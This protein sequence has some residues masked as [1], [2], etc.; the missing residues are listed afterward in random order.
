[1]WREWLKSEGV[2]WPAEP[3]GHDA[4][5]WGVPLDARHMQTAWCADRAIQFFKL[6]RDFTP[7][8][9]SVNIFQPHHPFWPAREYFDRY[10]PGDVAPPS[11]REG[12]LNNKPIYQRVDHAGA[13]GG[14]D[15]S[16]RDTSELDHRRIKAAY[17][18]M[19]EQCDAE[20]GRMLEALEESGQADNTIVIFMSDHGEMLGD[21]GIFLKGPYFYE[22]A[23]R[24]PM[25]IRW[26]HRYKA[27]LRSDALVE[28]VDLAPTLLEAAGLPPTVAMQGRSL[29]PLLTG[30]T[31]RHRDSVYCEFYDAYSL[32]DPPPMAVSVR[33]EQFKLNFFQNL[34]VS[35]LYDLDKDP[36]E[37]N[38]L[39][40]ESSARATR[41][42]MMQLA[43]TR[44]ID[45]I[46]PTPVRHTMW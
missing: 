27:G 45:T 15:L 34:P 38:N 36:G 19:I 44:M 23:I 32:Y 3:E 20:V 30:Q 31:T 37:T 11:Y 7:W 40:A 43:L 26:P 28:M 33:N 41:D 29:T 21:H 18:A 4:I 42:M 22:P 39:W 5:A 9:M 46:D 13:T 35:E 14:R 16:F 6:Q 17:Y 12:E 8:L 10:R 2:K 25:I 24:V 1:M